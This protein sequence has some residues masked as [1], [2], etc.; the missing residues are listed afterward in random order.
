MNYEAPNE[1]EKDFVLNIKTYFKQEQNT[2]IYDKRNIIKIVEFE[3]KKY[4]VKSF[5]I[6]HLV[7]QIVYRFFRD[8]KAKRSFINSIKLAELN[9]S[10]PQP[11]GF[12]EFPTAFKFKESFYIS[13]FFDFDFEIRAVFSDKEFEDRENIL[14]K[15]IA[16]TYQLHE[17]GVYHIDYSPGNILVKKTSYGYKFSIIDVNRM[18]FTEFND[19]LRM[20][21]LAK[22]TN[23][24]EDNEFI[25][26]HYAHIAKLEESTLLDKFNIALVKQ[27]KYLSNKK[28]LK[29]IKGKA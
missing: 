14:K 15:F 6:P 29:K 21:S 11:I 7:N 22:L 3:G 5:K 2:V 28:R 16:Y 23:D 20:Q 9:I 18:Q 4:V 13:E 19:D 8:S 17:K 24:K 25:A 10:T 1:R 12:I 27:E 26:K